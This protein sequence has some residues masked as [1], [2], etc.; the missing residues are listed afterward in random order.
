MRSIILLVFLAGLTTGSPA[1]GDLDSI[2][3]TLHNKDL[4][5]APIITGVSITVRKPVINKDS[6][7]A[8]KR[9]FIVSS[10][11]QDIRLLA[12]IYSRQV[13]TQKLYAL[14][15]D[16][17][18]DMY[19]SALLYDLLDNHKLGNLLFMSREKWISGGQQVKDTCY[20]DEYMKKQVYIY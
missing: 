5:V 7:M 13:I 1:Q 2:L 11:D 20:W 9:F 14:L 6:T 4:Y 3:N 8:K 15:Q 10:L 12:G 19:A 16:P 17:A 18:R